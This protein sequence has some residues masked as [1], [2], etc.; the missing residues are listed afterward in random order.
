M[1]FSKLSASDRRTLIV[2]AVVAVIGLISIADRWGIGAVLGFL[3]ALVAAGIILLP[4]LSPATRLPVTRGLGLLAG[5]GLS[6][7][8]FVIAAATWLSYV[9]DVTAISNLIFD[10]GLILSFV[11]L[12]FGWTAYQEERPA[13]AAAP[14]AAPAAAAPP[15]PPTTPEDTTPSTPR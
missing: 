2:A 7:V 8:G 6:A 5:G 9:L 11:L 12:Y 3:G 4:Q 10:V 13:G 1:D 15:P 14:S